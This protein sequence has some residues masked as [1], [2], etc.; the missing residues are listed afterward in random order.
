MSVELPYVDLTAHSIRKKNLEGMSV[1]LQGAHLNCKSEKWT[2]VKDGSGESPDYD[3]TVDQICDLSRGWIHWGDIHSK[4]EDFIS[5][6]KEIIRIRAEA[7][8]RNESCLQSIASI[9]IRNC[10][11]VCEC[12]LECQ[13]N[14]IQEVASTLKDGFLEQGSVSDAP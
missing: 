5:V 7:P 12:T 10:C 13:E 11:C 6:A 4:K 9:F 1:F 14:H 3:E 8:A 2:I